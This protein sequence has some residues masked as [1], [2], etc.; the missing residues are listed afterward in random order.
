MSKRSL[1][2]SALILVLSLPVLFG[3]LIFPGITGGGW[4]LIAKLSRIGALS[5]LILFAVQIVIG[6]KIRFIETAFGHDKMIGL[7]RR[8]GL[9]ALILVAFHAAVSVLTAVGR[10][11]I[12][13]LA[14]IVAF[15]LFLIMLLFIL[16][17]KI[18]VRTRYD[19]WEIAHQLNYIIFPL[20]FIHSLLLGTSIRFNPVWLSLWILLG[21]VFVATVGY[22]VWNYYLV[23]KLPFHVEQVTKESP[24]IWTIRFEPRKVLYK[25]GQF[26]VLRF[27]RDGIPGEP[28]P[29]TIASSP[30]DVAFSVSIK[31][32]GD[33]TRTI[34]Q[35]KPGDLALIDAPYGRFSFLEFPSKD[36]IFIAGGIGIT[37]IMS[38]LRYIRDKNLDL[39]QKILVLWG[40]RTE[41]DIVFRQEID[42]MGKYLTN[43]KVVHVLSEAP[44]G[45]SGE[46]GFITAD[47]I[48]KYA[49]DLEGKEI[50]ICGPPIMLKLVLKALKTLKVPG[51]RIHFERF[52]W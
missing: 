43:V 29:F 47:L 40:N 37:P 16:I 14:G 30:S 42:Q 4:M 11:E 51:R 20:A 35:V 38:M 8:F 48:R 23:C 13:L 26:M 18:F 50:F 39:E 41:Q 19:L 45:W 21:L 1:L 44:E 6:A 49:E 52:S 5:G 22:K 24:N 12:G 7:H 28:H 36:Y 3:V 9:A 46:T 34:G 32:A 2:I 31:E 10:E 33:F 15:F 25:P 27:F 17:K